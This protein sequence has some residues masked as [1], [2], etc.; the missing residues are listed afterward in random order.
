MLRRLVLVC[1]AIILAL[2]SFAAA[3]E[4]KENTT[5]AARLNN[6]GA[7]YM[8]QQLFEKALKSFSDAA[9]LD[10]HLSIANINRGIAL[11]NI[12]KADDAKKLL[13][14]SAK[15]NPKDPH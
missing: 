1:T 9:V 2:S 11:L 15:V 10:A 7:A 5:E 3:P 4:P 12:G 8:N 6:V 14:E 13:E